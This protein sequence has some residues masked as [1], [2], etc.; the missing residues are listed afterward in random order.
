MASGND[1]KIG[2]RKSKSCVVRGN[3][4]QSAGS[5]LVKCNFDLDVDSAELEDG[6]SNRKGRSSSKV[7]NSSLPKLNRTLSTKDKGKNWKQWIL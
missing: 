5:R 6:L 7:P 4:D 2:F 3:G 1:V